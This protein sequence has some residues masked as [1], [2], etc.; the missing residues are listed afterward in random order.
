MIITIT[1][2][3]QHEIEKLAVDHSDALIAF[4]ADLYRSG[5]L[6]G[7]RIG[8]VSAI[9][10]MIVVQAINVVKTIKQIKKQGS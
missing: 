6:K 1:K 3:Q 5:L 7:A 10:G 8:V 4:G 9:G 2:T